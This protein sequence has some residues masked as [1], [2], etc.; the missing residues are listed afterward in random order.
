MQE[1]EERASRLS[2]R[3]EAAAA[4]WDWRR[5][6]GK[7]ATGPSASSAR[8][9]AIIQ[10]VV[11]FMVGTAMLLFVSRTIGLIALGLASSILLAGLLSPSGLYLGIQRLFEA[12]GNVVGK[13]MTWIIM[14]PLFYLF[15]VP[16]GLLMRRG[17]RDQLKCYYVPEA[18][19]Y[20]EPHK[21]LT[22]ESREHQF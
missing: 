10:S 3:P 8:R 5:E 9:K 2:G 11:G 19:S 6:T 15:F 21:T 14:V 20:W 12:T 4:I 13:G 18:A 16:F 7:D 1:S 22:A 17:R